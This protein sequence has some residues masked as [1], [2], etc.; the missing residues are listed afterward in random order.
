MTAIAR[1]AD[2]ATGAPNLQT[3]E[4]VWAFYHH[5]CKVA[6][7]GSWKNGVR[8]DAQGGF[9]VAGVDRG[10]HHL[11]KDLALGKGG[12]ALRLAIELECVD[13]ATFFCN[14]QGP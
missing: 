1:D 6:P 3:L 7:R 4:G 14:V 10:S 12:L 8:H 11:H 5:A 2:V 9:D 13:A